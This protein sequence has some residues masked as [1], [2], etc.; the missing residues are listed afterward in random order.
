MSG[1]VGKHS[2]RARGVKEGI[3]GLWSGNW[4]RGITS[5]M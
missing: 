1:Q 3:G 2:H 4:E 5:E